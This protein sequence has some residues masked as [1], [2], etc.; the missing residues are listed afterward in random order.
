MQEVYEELI[1]KF[2]NLKNENIVVAVSGGADSITL[3]HLMAR[4]KKETN[5]N[6][7][8]AHVNHNVRVESES[9]KVFVEDFCKENDVIYENRKL[10]R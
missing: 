5:I 7:I 6:V 8:C 2:K 4:V 10:W 1:E 3:L 9:E